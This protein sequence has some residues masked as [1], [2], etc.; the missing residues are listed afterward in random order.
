[1][2]KRLWR[3]PVTLVSPCTSYVYSILPDERS[4]YNISVLSN[5]PGSVSD[6]L[7]LEPLPARLRALF[8]VGVHDIPTLTQGSRNHAKSP[9][10][11]TMED[12]MGYGW[13]AFT[14]DDILATKESLYDTL[15]TIPP[16][17]TKNAKNKVWPRVESKRGTEVKAT[18]R[19]LRRYRTLRRELR[20][21]QI[22][23]RGQKSPYSPFG[24][25]SNSE[26]DPNS[27][28]PIENTQETFDDASSTSDEKLIEP[29]S[30]SAL[31]YSSFMWWASAGEKRADLEEEADYDSALLRDFEHYGDGSPNRPRS[32]RSRGPES[33]TTAALEMAVIAYFHRLTALI[34]GTLAEIIDA[35]NDDDDGRDGEREEQEEQRLN[36]VVDECRRDK[37]AV[38]ITSEDM[39]RMGLDIWSE[40]DRRLV[41]ELVDLY[42]G[43][44]AEVQGAMVEC[45]GIR[46]C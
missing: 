45:C 28:F 20:R 18:Q 12:D 30:W 31:A 17:Y 16:S 37:E 42:W 43:R 8:S 44:Q 29:Q 35:S 32:S 13:V 26:D 34:L 22:R 3:F 36:G 1:M 46:I 6:L 2:G 11:P 23:S 14:T 27:I 21:H 33:G 25:N 40:G 19:D 38:F 24:A 39:A 41:K 4:V 5:I 10:H 15:V 9:A 7:P